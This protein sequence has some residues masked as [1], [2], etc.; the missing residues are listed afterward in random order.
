M[1]AAA[2][3]GA[4]VGII[5]IAVGASSAAANRDSQE[6]MNTENVNFMQDSNQLNEQLTR[7][8]WERDDN[9]VQRRALDLAKA[10]L[11]PQL[12]AGS[13]AGVSSPIRM[14]APRK[15]AAQFDPSGILSSLG[16]VGKVGQTYVDQKRQQQEA[17]ARY[18]QTLS[19]INL[20][21]ARTEYMADQVT[22]LNKQNEM[23]DANIQHMSSVLRNMEHDYNIAVKEGLPV[24]KV[25]ENQIRRIEFIVDKLLEFK[26]IASD[27]PS[28]LKRSFDTSQL[29]QAQNVFKGEVQ[30]RLLEMQ[31]QWSEEQEWKDSRTG[32]IKYK[33][34]EGRPRSGGGGRAPKY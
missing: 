25:Q 17:D 23:I 31:N 20:N 3:I 13:A 6:K 12:A 10:G 5:G 27:W 34:K 15:E 18:K 2:I 4:I 16:M 28:Q 7:E 24:G 26:D 32:L 29:G 21:T 14:E 1:L 33:D 30:S 19:E 8:S 22:H 11:A 9:A